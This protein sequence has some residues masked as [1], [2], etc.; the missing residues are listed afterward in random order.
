MNPGDSLVDKIFEEGLK[1]CDGVI[2]VL[3]DHSVSSRWVREELNVGFLRRIEKST[4]LIPVRID[5]CEVPECLKSTIWQDIS[6]LDDCEAQVKRIVNAVYGQYDKPALGEPPV[7]VASTTPTLNGL[8]RIDSN[9]LS[10]MCE[11]A[12][13][14]DTPLVHASLLIERL[15]P[16][17]ITETDII[18]TQQ[19]LEG[20]GLVKL[21]RVMGP[22]HAYDLTVSP[23]GFDL[24][25]HAAIPEY[26]KLCADVARHL[27]R[28][29]HMSNRALAP[30]LNQP[31]RLI[32]HILESLA[33]NGYI[34]YAASMG[35]GLHMDVYWVSP[36]LRRMLEA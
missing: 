35:G 1:D 2:I 28:G 23:V 5:G 33:H 15:R 18:E 6:D 7:H 27:V 32:E 14:A 13:E 17:G 8:T 10:A 29:E 36:E 9:I 22:E 25:A 4:R 11:I 24:F 30:A 3:S 16:M 19:V 31:N 34:K 21:H 20:R 12:I 26:G